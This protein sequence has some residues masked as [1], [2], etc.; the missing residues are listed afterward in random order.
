MFNIPKIT[1]NLLIINVIVYLDTLVM[2]L[3]LD[4]NDVFGLHFFL[5]PV[6]HF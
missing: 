4:L 3:G 5:A 1:K 6:F 2:W